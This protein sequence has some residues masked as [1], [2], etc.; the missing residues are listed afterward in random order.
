MR[1][2][3][4]STATAV[5]LATSF[6]GTAFG[7]THEVKSG[8]SLWKIANTYSTTVAQLRD[9]NHLKGDIIFPKQILVVS[10][11]DSVKE[12]KPQTQATPQATQTQAAK[13]YTVK[14]GDNL[15]KIGLLHKVTVSELYAWNGL[16][17]DLIHP[18][19]VLNVS[20]ATQTTETAPTPAAPESKPAPQAPAATTT[21]TYKVVSGDTLGHIAVKFKTT[22][23]QLK[24]L[25]GLSSDLIRVGQVLKV[26]GSTTAPAPVAPVAPTKPAPTPAKPE[27]PAASNEATALI[28]VAK[29]LLGTKY[30]WGGT[31]LSGFDC[32]GF[33]Y[34]AFNQSGKKLVRTNTDGYF[35]RSF[36]VDKP[37]PG[38]L[39]FFRNTY[40]QGISH[41][42]IYIGNNEFIHASSSKVEI[43]NLNNSYWKSK[44]DGFKRFY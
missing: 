16:K 2:T 36:Y 20:K 39:V 30:V 9:W 25:N 34:Y 27:A 4:V 43:T 32:S 35:D 26:N 28:D 7:A 44:F 29:S 37:Q 24:S 40:K 23:S 21:D 5:M 38:D 14:S 12:T 17:S 19:Q 18:G 15:S 6:S 22:V 3:L 13:T 31:T 41:L 42:G 1:K 33:I 8:D 10:E 11:E